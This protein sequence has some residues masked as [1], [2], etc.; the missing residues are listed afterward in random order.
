MSRSKHIPF[1]VALATSVIAA[2][3][4]V[5]Q[6]A[7]A[8]DQTSDGQWFHG[9]LHTAQ[10]Q[11][12]SR[13]A[14]VVVAVID[15]GVAHHGD[16][17]AAVSDGLD[18]TGLG[19]DDGRTDLVGHGTA[20]AGLIAASGRVNGIAP[21]AKIISVRATGLGNGIG[22]GGRIEEGIRW[23]ADHG[24]TVIS[25]SLATVYTPEVDRAIQEAMAADIVVVA[26]IGNSPP[27]VAATY[28]AALPGVVAVGSVDRAGRHSPRSV[29]SP[30][31]VVSAPGVDISSTYKDGRYSYGTGT[32]NATAIVA[33]AVA[34][35]RSKYPNMPAT[36]VIHRL[37][38]TATDKGP[39]G[40]DDQYGYGVI[41]LVAALTADVPPLTPSAAPSTAPSTAPS[42]NAEAPA[43]EPLN[44]G[45]LLAGLAGL[46]I[47]VALIAGA[48]ILASRRR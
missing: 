37:T 11:K 36:E 19:S 45:I 3:L 21:A 12:T 10:A 28:P 17:D 1:R 26:A 44:L 31:V 47:L 15:T 38:A 48:V 30:K 43:D 22:A 39:K 25:I 46:L 20:M 9:F 41:N 32:S 14:G 16:L 29:V 2:N 34:L 23:A 18:L 4:A 33:G 5:G 35:V 24:A 13:G 7:A 8:A 42:K 6:I 40:R 27:D